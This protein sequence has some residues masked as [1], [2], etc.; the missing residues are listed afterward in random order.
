MILQVRGK[1]HQNDKNRA[2]QRKRK[3][4][5]SGVI[6]RCSDVVKLDMQKRAQVSFRVG[7][8][9]LRFRL[10]VFGFYGVKGLN[11]TPGAGN[12]FAVV[13]CVH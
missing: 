13:A 3:L 2:C 5:C 12:K 8:R 10:R 1:V 7:F 11:A 9:V 6:S 4:F